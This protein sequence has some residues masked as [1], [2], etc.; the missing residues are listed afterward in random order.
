MKNNSKKLNESIKDAQEIKIKESEHNT[1]MKEQKA[2]K[3]W[4]QLINLVF[5]K[6][7]IVSTLDQEKIIEEKRQT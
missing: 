5:N 3:V 7:S 2:Y 6:I 4:H 1:V